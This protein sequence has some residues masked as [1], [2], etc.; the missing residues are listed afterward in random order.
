M[1][2][3]NSRSSLERASR[4]ITTKTSAPEITATEE[5]KPISA[6]MAES[7]LANAMTGPVDSGARRETG[8]KEPAYDQD[9]WLVFL[10]VNGS[11]WDGT[12]EGW[13]QFR[14]SFVS[15]AAGEGLR[16]PATQFL[17]ELT[18]KSVR[19]RIVKFDQYDVTIMTVKERAAAQ[20]RASERME[21]VGTQKEKGETGYK[22]TEEDFFVNHK[23]DENA[24]PG[25]N[26]TLDSRAYNILGRAGVSN[27]PSDI[28]VMP[29]STGMGVGN[30]AITIVTS[31][32][33]V[34]F[35]QVVLRNYGPKQLSGPTPCYRKLLERIR[36]GAILIS[37][38]I[39]SEDKY[40]KGTIWHE[41][42][43]KKHNQEL[44]AGV[45]FVTEIQMMREDFDKQTVHD[46]AMIAPRSPEYHRTY[47]LKIGPGQEELLQQ[48]RAICSEKEFYDEFHEDYERITG[49]TLPKPQ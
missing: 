6:D 44:E 37:A 40:A 24:Y 49:N 1:W 15:R 41:A 16:V 35:K 3:K 23:D 4:S 13:A 2:K 48:L 27:G 46:W 21:E 7:D 20:A 30:N 26:E 12:E 22:K 11:E 36:V 17:D 43:H 32:K 34:A 5:P 38:G 33:V 18:T 47:G 10:A 8:G 29:D 9:A 28:L 31:D 14:Q 45:V 25:F 42:G 19:E 39:M